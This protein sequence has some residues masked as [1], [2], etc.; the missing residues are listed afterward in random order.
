MIDILV[1]YFL[2]FYFYSIVGYV[3]EIISIYRLKK[4]L[5]LNR[6][7]LLGPYLPIFGFGGLI[8]TV[9]LSRY[10]KELLTLFILGMF[11]CGTL[12]YFTSYLLEKIF[13]LRWW[14]Y[15]SRKYNINGRVCLETIIMF[16]VGAIIL[17]KFSNDVIFNILDK[18]PNH[19][20][21]PVA[22]VLFSIMIFDTIISTKAVIKLKSDIN[23]VDTK[24]ATQTLK[25]KTKESLKNNYFYYER[26]FKAFPHMI[27][28]NEGAKTIS[29]LLKEEKRGEKNEK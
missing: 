9:F 6:G 16:G 21:T 7:Y 26:I 19:I 29:K 5:A 22:V 25:K 11:Y 14:D 12:E 27:K 8:I 2:L 23:L 18:I 1:K 17:V 10:N 24:D 20:L 13:H 3:C 15:S 4:K 28:S